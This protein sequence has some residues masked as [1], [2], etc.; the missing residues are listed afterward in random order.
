MDWGVVKNVDLTKVFAGLVIAYATIQKA[1]RTWR[2]GRNVEEQVIEQRVKEAIEP[3]RSALADAK[4]AIASKD[5]YIIELKRELS[6]KDEQLSIAGR[7]A[8]E[9]R[10]LIDQMD[11]R[12]KALERR[13]R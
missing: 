7:K 11:E 5:A 9:Q 13:R 10:G 12:V 6:E 3:L 8:E 4:S 2:R 1:Y